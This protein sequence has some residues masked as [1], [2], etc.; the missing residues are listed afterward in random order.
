M[1]NYRQLADGLQNLCQNS[2]PI[3]LVY[4]FLQTMVI[5]ND[6]IGEVREKFFRN[7]VNGLKRDDCIQCP[8]DQDRWNRNG[9]RVSKRCERVKSQGWSK[10]NQ[11]ADLSRMI[12][13]KYCSHESTIRRADQSPIGFI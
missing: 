3:Q 7:D 11:F 1:R 12:Y 6:V 5:F 13:C 9:L 8:V 2:F 4:G 10:Q